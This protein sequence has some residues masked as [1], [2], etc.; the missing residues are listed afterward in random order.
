M[1]SLRAVLYIPHGAEMLR[2]QHE[3]AALC[4]ARGWLVAA[5]TADAV[6]ARRL[7][8]AGAAELVVVARPRHLAAVALAVAVVT[9]P[10]GRDRRGRPRRLR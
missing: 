10:P 1:P 3:C 2:W 6:T 5:V 4:R 7:I 9:D 8:L